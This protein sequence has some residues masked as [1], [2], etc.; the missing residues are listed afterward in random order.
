VIRVDIRAQKSDQDILA[1]IF[2]PNKTK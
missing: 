2:V 1:F